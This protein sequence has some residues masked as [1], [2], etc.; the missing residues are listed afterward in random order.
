MMLVS[1][2]DDVLL[3]ATHEEMMMCSEVVCT[4]G[5]LWIERERV[6]MVS[7]IYISLNPPLYLLL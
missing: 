1:R 6:L 3:V 5:V 2:R 7:I 4:S